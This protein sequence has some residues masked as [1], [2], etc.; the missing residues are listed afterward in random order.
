MSTT[1]VWNSRL[2]LTP[3]IDTLMTATY[4]V[5]QVSMSINETV[6]KTGR[7]ANLT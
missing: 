2:L 5:T 4:N 1:A 7:C 3:S 6:N